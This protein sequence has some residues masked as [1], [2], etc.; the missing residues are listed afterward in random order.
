MDAR[1]CIA[2][3]GAPSPVRD[4]LGIPF[5]GTTN[6]FTFYVADAVGVSG[7]VGDRMNMRITRDDFL[8]TIPMGTGGRQ[9]L[10]GVVRNEAALDSSGALQAEVRRRLSDAFGVRYSSLNWFSTYRV[11]HRLADRFRQGPVFLAGDAAH[12]HSPVGA[13][14]M[15]TGVQDAHNLACKLADVLLRR[16]PDSSLNGYESERRPVAARLVRTTD[17]M[18]GV[19]TS[20]RPL[21]RF[22]RSRIVPVVVP[23]APRIAPRLPGASRIFG[24][25]SQT[26]IRYSTLR[27]PSR[28]VGRRL[29]WNGENYLPLRALSWQVHAYGLATAGD[30]DRVA[31]ALG[32]TAHSFRLPGPNGLK[33]GR[34][35]LVRP[36]GFLAAEARPQDAFN[37]FRRCFPWKAPPEVSSRPQLPPL[38]RR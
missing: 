3:D 26:R 32:V 21:P 19:V 28:I 30:A 24:Y 1:Y 38:S 29:P 34:L 16:A 15:N 14:G 13:Q 10:L 23:I 37:Q 33:P 25:L 35:Y 5:T 11:H 31:A 6:P 22:I 8:L 9:R 27:G 7:L 2:S 20:G 18:F 36:D 17:R 12:V 4:L